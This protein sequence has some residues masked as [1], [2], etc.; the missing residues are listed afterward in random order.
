MN[1]LVSRGSMIGYLGA[2]AA[3]GA[4]GTP[5]GAQPAKPLRID[6]HHHIVPPKW[7]AAKRDEINAANA[8]KQVILDWTV[9]RDIEELD[10]RGIT[11]AITSISTPGVWFGDVAEGR[12]LARDCNEF[13]ADMVRSYPGRIGMFAA[14]PLPDIEGSLAEIA[15]AYD[16]LKLDGIGLLT[17]YG[18]RWPGDPRFAPIFEE[19]N[20]RKAVVFFHPTTAACCEHVVGDLPPSI[21]EFGFNTT[22]AIES[23]LFSGSLTRYPNIRFIFAHGGGTVPFLA[24]RMGSTS[25]A[26][27][28]EV[29]KTLP[30]GA[31]PMLR[32]LFFDIVSVTNTPAMDALRAMM[33]PSQIL[34]GTDYPFVP[35]AQ[36]ISQLAGLGLPADVVSAIG[37]NAAALFP[38]YRS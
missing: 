16:T 2:L 29:A 36:T 13:G 26:R 19:L 23:L 22:R 3:T 30:D 32:K 7:Y 14:V 35:P 33:P 34:F 31:G 4:L 24:D 5:A 18:D 25:Y 1:P 37:Q 15:Y 28:P 38:R 12:R 9:A 17:S 21:V 27:R 11:T 20:R 10:R 8:N 6:T